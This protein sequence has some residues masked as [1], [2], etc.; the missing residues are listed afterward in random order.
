ML[1]RILW[2]L[3][4]RYRLNRVR[5]RPVLDLVEFGIRRCVV[6][7]VGAN[8]GGFA[9]NILLRAPLA[10]VHCF[11]P[12]QDVLPT[13]GKNAKR[14]GKT[15]GKP[16]CIVN[17]AGVG[18]ASET[19]EFIVTGLHAASSF[20]S[21]SQASRD[22]WPMADFSE[23]RRETVQIVRIDDYLEQHGLVAVKLMKIDVQGYELEVL[24]GCGD[25]LRDIEYIVS[26]VQFRQLYEAAPL[27][28]EIVDYAAEYGFQPVV[29]DGFCFAPDG[30]PLQADILLARTL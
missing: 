11:E 2:G 21:V 14:Y 1:R 4:H 25:R 3:R 26:E 30:Q 24:R 5:P 6:L 8:L 18:A 10:E 7:D 20:L 23:R 12:N 15:R 13:L 29:M 27:W 9:G 28:H 22:G 19:R 16:R 17:A